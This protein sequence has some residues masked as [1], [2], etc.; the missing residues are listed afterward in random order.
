MQTFTKTTPV[1]VFAVRY[2][3]FVFTEVYVLLECQFPFDYR[4]QKF[5]FIQMVL[6]ETKKYRTMKKQN[7]IFH[8][9]MII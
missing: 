3:L 1:N 5:F 4:A 2:K 9:T 6:P 8:I 7:R